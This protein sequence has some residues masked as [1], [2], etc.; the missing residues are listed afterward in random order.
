M[1]AITAT[2]RVCPDVVVE[3]RRGGSR[4]TAWIHG[5][6]AGSDR[7]GDGDVEH[8]RASPC[9]HL[10]ATDDAELEHAVGRAQPDGV[11]LRVDRSQAGSRASFQEPCGHD[12]YE[13]RVP[14]AFL[15]GWCPAGG[16]TGAIDD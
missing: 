2:A 16:G 7:T 11:E 4:F 9:R 14:G 3:V 12:R 10:G 13:H 5:E 15:G 6:V 8:D 1:R